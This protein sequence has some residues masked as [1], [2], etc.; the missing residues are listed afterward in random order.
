MIGYGVLT[1]VT[2]L[3]FLPKPNLYYK[4]EHELQP[5]GIIIHNEHIDDKRLWLEILDAELYVQKI[6]SLHIHKAT[7]MLFGVYNKIDLEQITLA[8]TLGQFVP[9][10]IQSARLRYALYDPLN[11]KATVMG[12]FGE[13]E[14]RLNIYDRVITANV[15]ASKLMKSKFSATLKNLT[16][17][18]KGVY[19]YEY[20][21]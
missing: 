5:Q 12:D 7:I 6:E 9:K 8:S 14:I 13:A 2:V 18:K 3:F 20:S 10:N 19:H 4:L 15:E 11:I 16:R 17:D 1:L 21:F